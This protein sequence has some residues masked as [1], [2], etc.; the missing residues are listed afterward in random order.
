MILNKQYRREKE[1]EQM[2]IR[3]EQK[4]THTKATK[5]CT[6][7]VGVKIIMILNRQYR[8]KK[9]FQQIRIRCQQKA[10][11]TKATKS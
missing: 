7:V 5:S 3:C 4:A 1:F 2:R 9:E 8:I 10:T 11:H 6:E